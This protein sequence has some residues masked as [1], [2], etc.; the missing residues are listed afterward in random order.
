MNAN[1]ADTHS[2]HLDLD[3]LLAEV[4]G[5]AITDRAQEHLAVCK[6]CRAEANRWALVAGGVRVLTAGAPEVPLSA[7]PRRA[8]PNVLSG[9]RRRTLLAASAAAALVL[10]GGTSYGVSAALTGHAPGTDRTGAKA[11]VLT[12]VNGCA[13]LEQAD[14]T[15]QQVNGTSLGIKTASGQQVL[16]AAERYHRRGVSYR[17]RPQLQRHYRSH[18]RQ[19]RDA[20]DR[21]RPSADATRNRR[22]PGDGIGRERRWLHRRHLHRHPGSGDHLKRHARP[23]IPR[24]PEPAAARRQH[25]RCRPRRTGRDTDGSSGPATPA[26]MA[27]QAGGQGGLLPRLDR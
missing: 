3:D 8:G 17:V 15:L 21:Q 27:R 12:A 24:Q 7:R 13:G 11:A 16:G 22:S 6:H 4:S 5:Q 19:R 9:P 25:H 26:G 23:P 20:A 14:G 1:P 10:I 2:P 18:G